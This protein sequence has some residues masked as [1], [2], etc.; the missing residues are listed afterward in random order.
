MDSLQQDKETETLLQ[1]IEQL[2]AAALQETNHWN[3]HVNPDRDRNED[4][5]ETDKERRTGGGV[6]D[7][8]TP[9]SISTSSQEEPGGTYYSTT[10]IPKN[11]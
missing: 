10:H 7:S 2:T 6:S 4:T 9:M 11:I 3:L 5:Q 8:D 1:E